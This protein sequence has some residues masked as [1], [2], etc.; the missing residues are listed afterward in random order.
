MELLRS[1]LSEEESLLL[2]LNALDETFSEKSSGFFKEFRPPDTICNKIPEVR[3]YNFNF[4]HSASS[5]CLIIETNL[6]LLMGVTR[7]TALNSCLL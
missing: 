4:I 5:Q 7:A 6:L 1:S 2:P 3:T